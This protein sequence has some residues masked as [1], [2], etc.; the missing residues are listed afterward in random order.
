MFKAHATG[1]I[2]KAYTSAHRSKISYTMKP[3]ISKPH[4]NYMNM[5]NKRV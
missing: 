1:I 5:Y 2:D 3:I 4:Y